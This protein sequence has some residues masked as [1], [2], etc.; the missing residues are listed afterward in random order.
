MDARALRAIAVT[1][2]LVIMLTASPGARA[3]DRLPDA[4]R[5]MLERREAI[6]SLSITYGFENFRAESARA[7]ELYQLSTEIARDGA[8]THELLGYPDGSL[9]IFPDGQTASVMPRR[10]LFD[11]GAIWRVREGSVLLGYNTDPNAR[12]VY[13]PWNL[14]ALGLTFRSFTDRANLDP[15]KL[16]EQPFGGDVSVTYKESRRGDLVQ[17]VGEGPRDAQVL[18]EIEPEKGWNPT[19]LVLSAGDRRL[20]EVLSDLQRFGQVWFPQ[21]VEIRDG[22][23]NIV[24]RVWVQDFA[25][26]EDARLPDT[27]VP[28]DI[29]AESGMVIDPVGGTSPEFLD[30]VW[31]GK[32]ILSAEDWE[33]AKRAGIVAPSRKVAGILEKLHDGTYVDPDSDLVRAHAER[34]HTAREVLGPWDKYVRD[35]E[36]RYS[37]DDTQTQKAELILVEC[38]DR[39]VSYCAA[40]RRKIEIS[41]TLPPEELQRLMRPLDDIFEHSLKPRLDALLTRE[42]RARFPASSSRPAG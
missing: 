36:K 34:A 27:F 6:R 33:R 23:G 18:W 17:V 38:K 31:D 8:M 21:T 28:A 35:F 14:R 20:F 9:G 2:A 42:Q 39:A 10:Y 40:K 19:R 32:K 4:L 24:E 12:E 22:D 15:R 29:G 1:V 5:R 16:I 25:A 3:D 11:K 13:R 26:N 7:G 41:S 37:L 30:A